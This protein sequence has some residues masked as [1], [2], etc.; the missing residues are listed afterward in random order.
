M[1]KILNAYYENEIH[2]IASPFN[3]D[4]KNI[5]FLASE[6]LISGE[7]RP[8][9]LGKLAKNREIYYLGSGPGISLC[10]TLIFLDVGSNYL[11]KTVSFQAKL[12][13]R[14]SLP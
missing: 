8:E 3:E 2:R 10:I 7:G 11:L 13:L 1:V 4:S 6:V 9:N 12:S 5:I 14:P